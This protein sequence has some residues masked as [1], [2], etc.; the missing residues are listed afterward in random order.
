MAKVLST[1]VECVCVKFLCCCAVFCNVIQDGGQLQTTYTAKVNSQVFSH[2]ITCVVF[3][4]CKFVVICY[5][6]MYF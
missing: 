4:V 3:I 6:V 2:I 1:F 5:S